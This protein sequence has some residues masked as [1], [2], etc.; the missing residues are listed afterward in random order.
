MMNGW[1][2]T[3]HAHCFDPYK[4]DEEIHLQQRGANVLYRLFVFIDGAHLPYVGSAIYRLPTNFPAPIQHIART[5]A[6]PMCRLPLWTYTELD[7]HVE[8][9]LTTGHRVSS[10]MRTTIGQQM[11][12]RPDAVRYVNS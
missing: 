5:P 3:L 2:I 9:V 1:H 6:N 12:N 4:G 7:L 10:F 8:V 11:S